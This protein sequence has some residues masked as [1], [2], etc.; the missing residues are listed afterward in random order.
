MKKKL[1]RAALAFLAA[2]IISAAALPVFPV[3]AEEPITD[4]YLIEQS[5]RNYAKE[6][7]IPIYSKV[8][9]TIPAFV[10][11]TAVKPDAETLRAYGEA[12]NFSPDILKIGGN[13]FGCMSLFG[14]NHGLEYDNQPTVMDAQY[15]L[16]AVTEILAGNRKPMEGLEMRIADV[17]QDDSVNSADAQLVLLYYVQNTL[18]GTPTTWEDL[19]STK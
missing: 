2:G 12:Q 8:I 13:E 11:V 5:V 17:N 19:L 4:A 10:E 6:H 15:I 16:C 18:A 3:S 7:N 1:L 9:D 14:V